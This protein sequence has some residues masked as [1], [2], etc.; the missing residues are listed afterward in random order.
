[1]TL[2]AAL[3]VCETSSL[4]QYLLHE[5]PSLRFFTKSQHSVHVCSCSNITHP[6]SMLLYQAIH[7]C[8]SP[9][10]SQ[11]ANSATLQHIPHIHNIPATDCLWLSTERCCHFVPCPDEVDH[12]TS[13]SEK[14]YHFKT[15]MSLPPCISCTLYITQSGQESPMH[16]VTSELHINFLFHMP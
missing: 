2:Q 15:M 16:M 1:V 12:R 8:Y 10:I 11:P 5:N 3:Q 9:L 13:H 7:I 6:T 4:C 14:N